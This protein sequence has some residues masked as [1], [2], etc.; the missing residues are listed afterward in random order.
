[1]R[2]ST[3]ASGIGTLRRDGDLGSVMTPLSAIDIAPTK[4]PARTLAIGAAAIFAI[5]IPI[6]Q[7][8]GALGQNPE[9]FAAEGD[10]TLKAAGYAFAIWTLIYIGLGAFAIYQ[11]LPRTENSATLTRFGWPSVIA[12]TGCGLW[13]I[14]AAQDLQWATVVIIVASAL[15]L[16]IPLIRPTPR[17][18]R[19]DFWLI[20]TPL[21]LLAGWLTIAASINTLTVM[22]AEGMISD[23]LLWAAG[24][25][26]AVTV[27]AAFVHMR[28]R[29]PA[30]LAPII[31]GLAAVA[32]AE[33]ERKPEIAFLAIG[34]AIVLAA[35][36]VLIRR[37]RLRS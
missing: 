26:I 28:A 31:W 1:M 24:G 36:A 20:E 22:T 35:L 15:A 33:Y 16:I 30:Y 14:A 12:M 29:T 27:I 17:Q 25:L 4:P 8:M 9:A 6:A 19:A 3:V 5:A 18:S 7:A 13:L 2:P 23:A 34:A 10:T 37:P 32:V 21:A 11:A